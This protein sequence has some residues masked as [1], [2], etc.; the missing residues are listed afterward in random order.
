MRTVVVALIM[1]LIP[2]QCARNQEAPYVDLKTLAGKY[3]SFNGRE[4]VVSGTVFMQEGKYIVL[5]A[6][7]SK[8]QQDLLFLV[9]ADSALQNPGE[10]EKNYMNWP[11]SYAVAT[12]RGLFVA[13]K[14]KSFGHQMCCRFKLEITKVIRVQE[15]KPDRNTPS[16][17]R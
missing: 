8:G 11:G 14:E 6:P 13:A 17:F 1:A 10:L 9:M 7:T 5:P 4:I 2:P 3:K 16:A 12:L 15:Y